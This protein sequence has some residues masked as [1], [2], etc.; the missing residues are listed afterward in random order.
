MLQNAS[1]ETREPQWSSD[2]SK[3]LSEDNDMY[4]SVYL[5]ALKKQKQDRIS[6]AETVL[7]LQ[8]PNCQSVWLSQWNNNLRNVNILYETSGCWRN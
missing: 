5:W 3:H 1:E 6:V 8:K 2:G 4:F 7:N